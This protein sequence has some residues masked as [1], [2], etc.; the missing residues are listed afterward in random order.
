[1]KKQVEVTIDKKVY[2]EVGKL[3][4]TRTHLAKAFNKAVE[5]LKV[6][7]YMGQRIQ[8]SRYPVDIVRD[9]NPDNLFRYDLIRRHP[10]WRMLYTVKTDGNIKVVAVILKVVD[11]HKY[12]VMF[13]Y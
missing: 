7:P 1:M 8:K 9:F 10:G 3:I 11:H 6:N 5:R 13:K 12:D 2:K 4:K